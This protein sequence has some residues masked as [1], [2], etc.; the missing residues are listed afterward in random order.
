MSSRTQAND[1]EKLADMYT[2]GNYGKTKC[3]ILETSRGFANLTFD[4]TIDLGYIVTANVTLD[5][6]YASY[7]QL[8]LTVS[9][10]GPDVYI[11]YD[12][13]VYHIV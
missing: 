13:C 10:N 11:R 9:G 5:N 6:V 7:T 8:L 2:E 4:G 12:K 3:D 1:L